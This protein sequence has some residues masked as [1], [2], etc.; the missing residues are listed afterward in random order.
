MDDCAF[1]VAEQDFNDVCNAE[2]EEVQLLVASL[3]WL[4]DE[5]AR[6]CWEMLR[7]ADRIHSPEIKEALCDRPPAHV[8]YHIP[9]HSGS[10]DHNA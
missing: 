2:I 3:L 9:R 1:T 7:V 10:G 8:L 6:G 4:Y 5:N